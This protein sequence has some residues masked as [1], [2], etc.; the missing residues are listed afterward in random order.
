M[1]FWYCLMW[2]L[3]GVSFGQWSYVLNQQVP[4]TANGNVLDNPWNGGLNSVQVNKMDL[5]QDG[6]QDLVLFDRTANKV[7]TYLS[8]AAGYQYAPA[9]EEQ[10]PATINSWMLLRDFNCDGKKD[11]FT[12]D[13]FGIA[14]FVNTT[15]AGK[16]ISWRPFNPG[17]PLLEEGLSGTVN[18]KINANDI[19]AIDDIDGDGDLDILG[20]RFVG[21]GT[22]E[23]YQNM[24]IERAGKC[25]SLQLKLITQNWGNF[26]ECS[27]G[28]FAFGQTCASLIGGRTQHV[29]GKALLTIDLDGDGDRELLFSEESCT[30]VFLLVNNGSA[31]NASFTSATPFPASFPATM[32]NFPAPFLEDLDG[33]LLNDLLVS[34]TMYNRLYFGNN[35]RQSLWLYKNTGSASQPAFT[36]QQKNFLQD[37]MIDAGDNSVPALADED[38]DGD[39]DLFIGCNVNVDR[40]SRGTLFYYENTGT[41]TLPS[42]KLV[43]DDYLGF[44]TTT[45][46]NL[47]PYFTDIDGNGTQDLLV[48][49]TDFT[50]GKDKLYAVPNPSKT[51]LDFSNPTLVEINFSIIEND[52]LAFYDINAD[53]KMDILRGSATGAL[54]YW[55]N[56]GSQDIPV[57]TRKSDSFLGIGSST[58]RQNPTVALGD[59]NGDGKDDAL[60]GDQIGTFS[61]YDDFKSDNP[62]AFGVQIYDSTASKYIQL[63]LGGRVFP[64]IGNIFRS[65]RPVIITGNSLGG[66][67]LLKNVEDKPNQPLPSIALYPIPV[68]GSAGEV[69]NIQSDQPTEIRFFTLLGQPVGVKATLIANE[70]YQVDVSA[71]PKGM[72]LA[73]FTQKSGETMTRRIIVN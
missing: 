65:S 2:L 15:A 38:G 51:H 13:P 58:S 36:L 9:F 19:P 70:A 11:L 71:W 31:S 8:T 16:S 68:A 43:T 67:F 59:L 64:V 25:D 20:M 34:P 28:Q 47:R 4:V 73:R 23:Y 39:L 29:G 40:S 48:T 46:F 54:E 3:P 21:I 14:V 57:Y 63:N 35:L 44:S 12:S 69:L 49:T 32:Q 62:L 10:F 50:D 52:N 45:F 56:T 22:V 33:D 18:L 53:G 6:K 27:C 17:H 30:S 55:E 41:P 37:Q 26:E 61:V 5:N 24:S 60:V 1:K 42:Y 66:L 7:I 72:Y